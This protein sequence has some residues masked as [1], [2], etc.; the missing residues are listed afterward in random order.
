[1]KLGSLQN[2]IIVIIMMSFIHYFAMA[3]PLLKRNKKDVLEILDAKIKAL[4]NEVNFLH[5][6]QNLYFRTTLYYMEKCILARK[7]LM[8]LS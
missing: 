5:K 6:Y 2:F 4:V 1:M 8:L 3:L 7:K